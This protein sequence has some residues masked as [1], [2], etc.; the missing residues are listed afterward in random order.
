MNLRGKRMTIKIGPTGA[1]SEILVDGVRLD[2]VKAVDICLRPGDVTLVKM[3]M[4]AEFG[5]IWHDEVEGYLLSAEEY[6]A[7][8]RFKNRSLGEE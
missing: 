4:F 5:N 3:E 7:W 8:K 1:S 2:A 6:Q